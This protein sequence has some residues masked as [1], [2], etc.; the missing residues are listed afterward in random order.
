[1]K[2]G[3]VKDAIAAAFFLMTAWLVSTK[4]V[5]KNVLLAGLLLGFTVDCIFTLNTE[6][7]CTDW[8]YNSPSK[9]VIAAQVVAFAYFVYI[10]GV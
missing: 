5:K 3:Q 4:G 6:W 9:L 2:T 1:M 10:N 8:D 7:H